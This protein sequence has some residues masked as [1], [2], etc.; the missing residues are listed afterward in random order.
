MRIG[1]WQRDR[2]RLL[3]RLGAGLSP[4]ARSMPANSFALD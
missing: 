1:P 4:C 3:Q 2:T